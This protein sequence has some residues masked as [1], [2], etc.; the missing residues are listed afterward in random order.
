MILPDKTSELVAF[1]KRTID[2][3]R[4]S[5]AQRAA[6]YRQYG[7][8]VETGR[9]AGGL[10]LCNVLYGHEDRL[11]SHLYSP[12]ELRFAIDYENIYEKE[13]LEKGAVAARVVS[14]I[15]E[16][17][18]IDIL[19]GHGVKEALDYGWCGLKQ[20]AG[21]DDNGIFVF[22]GA[23]LVM[24]W[25]FGVYNEGVNSFDDQE[26]FVETMWLN[27]WEVWRRVRHLPNAEALYNRILGNANKE[28][29]VGAPTSFMHQ[30]LSTAVL[31]TSLQNMTQPQ[32]GGIVQLTNDPNFS[33][34][35]P[36]IAT[37]LYPMHELWVR[38]DARALGF[39]T[40]V[41]FEPDILVAPTAN[42]PRIN[43]FIERNRAGQNGPML[44]SDDHPYN[45]IYAN[46]VT[47]YFWNRSEIVDLMELQ[48]WLTEHLDDTKRLMGQQIDKIFGFTGDGIGDEIM[49]T[50]RTSGYVGAP[51]GS[52]I[53]DFTPKMPEQLIPI[54]GQILMLM[55][56]A[57]GFPP[58]MSGQGEPGVRAGVHADTLMKTGSPRLRDRSLLIE[59]LVAAAASTTL[60]VFKAK[61]PRVYWTNPQNEL[62]EFH[63]E[64]LPEDARIA[65]D[66]HSA[67]PI[68]HDDQMQLLAF[69]LKAGVV[70]PESFIEQSPLAHKD[71]LIQRLKEK[72]QAQQVL[73]QQHPEFF[74]RG[75]TGRR[76]SD[77]AA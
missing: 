75:G 73:M 20:I 2:D 63:L 18:D 64:Q 74:A 19:F 65:V 21:R 37:E 70:T 77:L 71:I 53:E 11:A 42:M 68:Y 7:Q 48:A 62:T 8:W 54:T 33:T 16:A 3:C 55:D 76:K 40:I 17:K 69:G 10:A 45:P 39:T 58:I 31:D 51:T 6:A 47:D 60:E 23:R 14:R 57:S 35:G 66:S 25:N 44:T 34:L 61:D 43:L 49:A 22:K 52:K 28:T 27:K 13:W 15:W 67:S 38:N 4:A 29:G 5:Q 36:T 59:R 72:E 50:F 32:P 24:P 26:A 30:V 9:M 41:M 12:S 1:A 56:R 46:H